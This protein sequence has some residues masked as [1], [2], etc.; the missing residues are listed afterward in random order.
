MRRVKQE[1]VKSHL[2]QSS[3]THTNTPTHASTHAH[4]SPNTWHVRV[5]AI[6][7]TTCDTHKLTRAYI[8]YAKYAHIP[9][10]SHTHRM[11]VHMHTAPATDVCAELNIKTDV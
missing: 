4:R 11:C 1:R 6:C 10:Y 2:S 5:Q 7:A 3:Y 9:R 8:D